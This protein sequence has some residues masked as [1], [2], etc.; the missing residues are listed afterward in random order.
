MTL[1]KMINM[2]SNLSPSVNG[3]ISRLVFSKMR[4]FL[5]SSYTSHINLKCKEI[6]N[7]AHHA[8]LHF[9]STLCKPEKQLS[10]RSFVVL[11]SDCLFV[12]VNTATRATLFSYKLSQD[13]KMQ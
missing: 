10:C 3:P 12:A 11:L 2:N 1:N 8:V 7:K 4:T 6:S 5:L 9:Q 13:S